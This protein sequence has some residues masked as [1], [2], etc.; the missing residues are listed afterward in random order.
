VVFRTAATVEVD[1]GML[2]G[3]D[4]ARLLLQATHLEMVVG[5]GR[6]KSERV[7]NDMVP[8]RVYVEDE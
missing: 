2:V 5:R 4:R 6:V 3:Y 1:S 7:M 8:S